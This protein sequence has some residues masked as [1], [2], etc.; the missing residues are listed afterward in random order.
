MWQDYVKASNRHVTVDYSNPPMDQ[1]VQLIQPTRLH[2]QKPEMDPALRAE[3]DTMKDLAA[4]TKTKYGEGNGHYR[5]TLVFDGE[6]NK[7][8]TMKLHFASHSENRYD[9]DVKYYN[10]EDLFGPNMSNV[11]QIWAQGPR[12]H[13]RRL[14]EDVG[15]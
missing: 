8:R 10:C 4:T 3:A 6:G 11:E 5:G 14:L 7:E 1:E 9:I 13:H 12:R 15:R 2:R